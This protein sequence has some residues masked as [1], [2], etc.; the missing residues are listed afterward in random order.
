MLKVNLENVIILYAYDKDGVCD[1]VKITQRDGS[2]Q[3]FQV[4]A[5]NE[6]VLII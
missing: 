2:C 5:N 1:K 4:D 6:M 3:L